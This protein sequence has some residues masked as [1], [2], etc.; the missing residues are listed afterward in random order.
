MNIKIDYRPFLTQMMIVLTMMMSIAILLYKS[1]WEPEGDQIEV[2]GGRGIY[3]FIID[4]LQSTSLPCLRHTCPSWLM[5]KSS[6]IVKLITKSITESDHSIDMWGNNQEAVSR[7]L[8]LWSSKKV[9]LW[10]IHLLATKNRAIL[11]VMMN[12]Q[13]SFMI[14]MMVMWWCWCRWQRWTLEKD[15]TRS[16]IWQ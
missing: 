1:W 3:Q 5:Q 2:R 7:S 12:H 6:Q 14:V 4:F 16:V 13:S 15:Q 11:A 8:Q 9:V 10:M